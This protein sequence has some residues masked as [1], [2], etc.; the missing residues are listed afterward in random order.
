MTPPMIFF[1][2]ILLAGF[3]MS[4]NIGANDVSNAMGT[5]VGSKAL[6]LKKAVLLAAILEFSGAFFLGG[7][8]SKTLQDGLI[9]FS[10]FKNTPDILM[11]GMF[12]ALVGTSIWLH[13]ASY[14]GWPVS[15]THA[16]VGAILGFG[17]LVGG[18][19]AVHW[20]EVSS[21]ASSWVISPVLS[22]I[23][24]FFC[25]NFLQKKVLF[26]LNPVKATKTLLPYL[27]SLVLFL[28][29]ST[30]LFNGLIHFDIFLSP[31]MVLLITCMISLFVF[32]LV[33]VLIHYFTGQ[34]TISSELFS[35]YPLQLT[36]I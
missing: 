28:F 9:E 27:F 18:P 35:K 5:S 30:A 19:K 4:W 2:L 36:S 24:S 25:F 6:T 21:I 16:I 34:E 10:I 14:L 13:V 7:N 33:K 15:T 26:S 8:V 22:G 23:I 17:F 31:Y 20:K 3:Y 12:S 32:I 1:V 29:L 11:I